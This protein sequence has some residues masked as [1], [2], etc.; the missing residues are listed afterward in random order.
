MGSVK[1]CMKSA[2]RQRFATGGQPGDETLNADMTTIGS[3]K[4]YASAPGL[5]ER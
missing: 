5:P 2:G 1:M 4:L 3:Q